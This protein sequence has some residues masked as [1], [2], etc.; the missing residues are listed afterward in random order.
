M[1]ESSKI[2]HFIWLAFSS[3]ENSSVRAGFSVEYGFF[4]RL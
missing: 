3:A 1:T 4:S 2:K